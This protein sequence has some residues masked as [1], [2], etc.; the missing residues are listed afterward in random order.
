MVRSLTEHS[1]E[2]RPLLSPGSRGHDRH[3]S[4]PLS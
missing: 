3:D 1:Q 4:P 2:E